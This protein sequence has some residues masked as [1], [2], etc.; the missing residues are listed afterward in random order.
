[1]NTERLFIICVFLNFFQQHFVVF[2]VQVFTSLAKF[3]S[4]YFIIAML[5]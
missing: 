3:I 5:L 4:S 1:M 2:S